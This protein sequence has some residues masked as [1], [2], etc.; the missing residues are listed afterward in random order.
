[1][2][3]YRKCAEPGCERHFIPKSSRNRFC[4]QHRKTGPVDP[5]H[6]RKYGPAHRALRI[7]LARQVAAGG[8]ECARCG[9]A[10]EPGSSGTSVTGTGRCPTRVRSTR[11]ATG[12]RHLIVRSVRGGWIRLL[13]FGEPSGG[14]PGGPPPQVSATPLSRPDRP[15]R[16]RCGLG[17]GGDV[18]PPPL[19][20]LG[21]DL[22][23]LDTAHEVLTTVEGAEVLPGGCA[24]RCCCP[25]C[26]LSRRGFLKRRRPEGPLRGRRLL[27]TSPRGSR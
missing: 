23:A 1:M 12:R 8:V 2:Y 18:S 25:R 15:K 11:G 13:G 3:D 7:R 10:I 22:S 20:V 5:M 21:G 24:A 6:Y 4:L 9:K 17:V 27:P 16:R 14:E 19:S 26:R